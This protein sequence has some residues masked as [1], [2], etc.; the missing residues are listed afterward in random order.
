MAKQ[1]HLVLAGVAT[2]A[3]LTL[4]ASQ[5]PIGALAKSAGHAD[6]YRVLELFDD[7]FEQV[8]QNYVEKPDDKKPEEKKPQ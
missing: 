1:I 7:A 6:E 2:G 5:I 4:L 8:R 3:A